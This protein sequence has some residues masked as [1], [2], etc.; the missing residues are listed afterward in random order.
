MGVLY[1][2]VGLISLLSIYNDLGLTESLQYFIPRYWIK[3][4]YNYIKTSIY[5]SLF[6]QI[7]TGILLALILWIAAPRLATHYFH[8]PEA[9]SILKYFCFY[10]LGINLFQVLQSIFYSFQNTFA[11]QFVDFVRM[12]SILGFT[13][14]FW[15]G[16]KVS[17]QRYSLSWIL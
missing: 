4:Q 7:S 2:V 15:L 16:N 14:L 8:S 3:K 1:S 12:W 6:I 10:F 17:I 9:V 13:V 5:L 11:Y